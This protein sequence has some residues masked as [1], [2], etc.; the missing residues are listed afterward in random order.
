MASLSER[1]D[2]RTFHYILWMGWLALPP[3]FEFFEFYINLL[4]LLDSEISRY[5]LDT[6]YFSAAPWSSSQLILMGL[7]LWAPNDVDQR[8]AVF[9]LWALRPNIWISCPMTC[10]IG[11]KLK[12]MISATNSILLLG[13]RTWYVLKNENL[14]YLLIAWRSHLHCNREIYAAWKKLG[15]GAKLPFMRNFQALIVQKLLFS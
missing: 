9:L 1:V 3:I 2:I 14:S 8:R 13:D 6:A 10:M 7:T 12:S 5:L 4:A 11:I 15:W